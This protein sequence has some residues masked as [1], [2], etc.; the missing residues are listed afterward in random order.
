MPTPCAIFLGFLICAGLLLFF[1]CA[2]SAGGKPVCRA[3]PPRRHVDGY[4]PQRGPSDPPA[5]IPN[6]ASSVKPPERRP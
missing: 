2:G 6:L 5:T 3:D 1:V 4:Q